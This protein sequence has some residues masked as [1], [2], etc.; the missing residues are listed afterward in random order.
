MNLEDSLEKV[1]DGNLWKQL[2]GVHKAMIEH[3]DDADTIFTYCTLR[4]D[5]PATGLSQAFE[6]NG[7]DVNYQAIVRHRKHRCKCA[8]RMPERYDT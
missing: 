4:V 2:C 8:E 1:T 7:I 6:S 5:K 3:P